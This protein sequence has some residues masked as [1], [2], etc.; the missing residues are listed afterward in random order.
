MR[1]C[2]RSCV[3]AHACI[4]VFGAYS[5]VT[6]RRSDGLKCLHLKAPKY[7]TFQSHVFVGESEEWLSQKIFQL[8]QLER[9]SLEK[10]NRASMGF[11]PVTSAIPVRCST[12]WAMKTDNLLHSTGIPEVTG[13]NPL[14]HWCF[15]WLLLSDCLKCLW[16]EKFFVLI[17]KAFQNTE[18]WRFSFWNIFFR[19]RDIDI[20]LLCSDDVIRFATQKWKILNK[21]YLWKY[22]SSV[23]ETWHHKCASQKKQNDNLSAVARTTV[24][25]LVVC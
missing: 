6:D 9:R 22:W 10:K 15:F 11:T 23:L 16:N 2:V 13:W 3:R 18:E 20:F 24:L 7:R 4:C 1:A 5:V 12:N 8:K 19:F 25:P 14:K 21:R 17:W